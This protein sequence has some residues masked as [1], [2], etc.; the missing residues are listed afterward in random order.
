MTRETLGLDLSDG[1]LS[2][3]ETMIPVNLSFDLHFG[4]LGH[5]VIKP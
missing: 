5:L 4:V 3:F 2:D 1:I